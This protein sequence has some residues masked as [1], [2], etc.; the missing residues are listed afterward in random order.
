M[1]SLSKTLRRCPV[2]EGDEPY[3]YFAFAGGDRRQAERIGQ[4]LCERGFRLWYAIGPAGSAE[5]LLQRQ[6]RMTGAALT[7]L[8]LSDAAVEDRDLKSAVLVN[9]KLDNAIVCLDPDGTDRRL[10]MGLREDIPHLGLYEYRSRRALEDALIRSEGVTQELIGEP[11]RSGGALGRLTLLFV[12][13]AALLLAGSILLRSALRPGGAPEPLDTVSVS[14]PVLLSAAREAAGGGALTKE[15]AALV[16]RLRLETLPES[17]D[18]LSVFPSLEIIELSQE[19]A[20]E[21]GELPGGYTLVL[22][23]GGGQ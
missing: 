21:P 3:I 13:L 8:Y 12:V 19:A 2:Y 11:V 6:K 22:Y 1:S 17:W 5:K 15:R 23:G 14:D 7:M 16:T 20:M 9:Q 10:A 4:V 18:G